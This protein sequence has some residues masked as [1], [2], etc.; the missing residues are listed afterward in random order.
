MPFGPKKKKKLKPEE[1][2]SWKQ[3]M[4]KNDSHEHPTL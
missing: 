2:Q 1:T 4:E 3:K